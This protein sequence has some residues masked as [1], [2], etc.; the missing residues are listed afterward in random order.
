MCLSSVFSLAHESPSVS[1]RTRRKAVRSEEDYPCCFSCCYFRMRQ[2]ERVPPLASRRHNHRAPDGNFEN[3][4]V[5]RLGER[6]VHCMRR[7]HSCHG[8][9]KERRCEV[10]NRFNGDAAARLKAFV[11]EY[12]NIQFGLRARTPSGTS[13]RSPKS[14]RTDDI[15]RVWPG[16]RSALARREESECSRGHSQS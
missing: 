15:E 7:I 1:T 3:S 10:K 9:E 11:R 6:R 2:S 5:E 16:L 13:S 4:R 14:K 8:D 12:R